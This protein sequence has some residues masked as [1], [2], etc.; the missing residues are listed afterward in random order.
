MRS[1]S[2]CSFPFF[3]TV[4]PRLCLGPSALPSRRRQLERLSDRSI[5]YFRKKGRQNDET[6]RERTLNV[7]SEVVG[8]ARARRTSYHL[9]H[10]RAEHAGHHAHR[11]G[12][13]RLGEL[14]RLGRGANRHDY[15]MTTR[16]TRTC[17]YG[18]IVRRCMSPGSR[19][20]TAKIE[21][22][23]HYFTRVARGAERPP[24]RCAHAWGH[25]SRCTGARMLL[26]DRCVFS[27]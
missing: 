12:E 22:E 8:S 7:H 3:P 26:C 9:A 20:I 21:K 11:A 24:E 13:A 16:P 17:Y 27:T 5:N 23:I 6:R 2:K 19:W 10:S 1:Y 4:L 25:L 14:L 15:S 18:T